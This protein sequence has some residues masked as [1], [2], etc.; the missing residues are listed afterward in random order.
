MDKQIIFL[1]TGA[2]DATKY[3]HSSYLIQENNSSILI[4]TGSGA[5]I[6]RQLE[7]ANIKLQDINHIFITH[8][9][10]DHILGIFWIMRITA[11]KISKDEIPPL[12]IYCSSQTAEIIKT[13]SKLLLKNKVTDLFD[14]KIIFNI[15]NDKYQTKLNEWNLLFFDT[16]SEKHEEYGLKIIFDDNKTFVTLGDEPYKN[17]LAEICQN[18]DY[19]LHEAFCLEDDR[20]IFKPEKIHHSTV[21]E[22]ATFANNMNAKNLILFHTEDKTFNHRKE[23]YTNEAKKNFKGTI[24]IPDDLETIKLR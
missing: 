4:D 10:T 14:N 3:F 21:K 8:K 11:S 13:I 9:H 2:P 17:S 22:A 16:K 15:I 12:H 7:L 19:I 6:L 23:L 20:E 5:Q 18:C 24:F 1:G